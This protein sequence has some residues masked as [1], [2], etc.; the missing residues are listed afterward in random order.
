MTILRKMVGLALFALTFLLPSGAAWSDSQHQRFVV[1]GDS[2]SDPG[3]ALV[4]LRKFEKPPFDSLIPAAPYARGAGHFSNGATWIEQLSLREHAAPSA[5][6]AL[7]LPRLFSNYAVGGATA[8]ALSPFDLSTQVSAFLHDFRA[9]APEQALYVVW[10]GGNDVR[11]ALQALA[12]DPTG[13]TSAGILTQAIESIAINLH[14]LQFAGARKFLIANAPDV[15]LTPAVRLQGPAAQGAASF[16]SARFNAGLAQALQGVE[17][18]LDVQIAR[19]DVFSI[20]HEVVAAPATAGLTNVTDACIRLN[21]TVGAF[22]ARP[23]DYLFWDGIHP[24]AAGHRILARRAQEA[25]N[26]SSAPVLAQ[27]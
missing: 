19:L 25:L 7:L 11:A 14:T 24:T 23:N 10:V 17:A 8:G 15:G 13:A 2:L 3:N 12:V 22:C 6:P 27:P 16:L 21:V 20:L 1:F 18:A 9:R 5:G 4:L 26:N